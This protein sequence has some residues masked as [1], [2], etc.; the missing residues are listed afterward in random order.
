MPTALP[1]VAGRRINHRTQLNDLSWGATLAIQHT[2]WLHNMR[3]M[4]FIRAM[5]ELYFSTIAST[6]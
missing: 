3:K 6:H 1:G 2:L 4:A 5:P